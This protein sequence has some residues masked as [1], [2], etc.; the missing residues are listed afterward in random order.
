MSLPLP[1]SLSFDRFNLLSSSVSSSSVAA[2]AF[3]LMILAIL[4]VTFVSL[5]FAVDL[6][7]ADTAVLVS[8]CRKSRNSTTYE[9]GLE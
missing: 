8:F 9:S 2:V 5:P 1:L 7:A 6:F 4:S 3:R